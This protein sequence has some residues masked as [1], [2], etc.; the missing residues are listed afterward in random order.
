M[1]TAHE[2]IWRSYPPDGTF[3]INQEFIFTQD[4]LEY[5]GYLKRLKSTLEKRLL[6]FN[7]FKSYVVHD[8]KPITLQD[9]KIKMDIKDI[10]AWLYEN[11]NEIDLLRE[12][13]ANHGNPWQK[14]RCE[15]VFINPWKNGGRLHLYKTKIL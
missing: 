12:H 15:E 9:L 8:W 10:A 2:E 1:N 7:Y 14:K 11:G 6:L 3:K 4:S 5:Q 13:F